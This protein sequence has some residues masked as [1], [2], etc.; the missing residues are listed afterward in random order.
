M[1]YLLDT[2][3]C[4]YAIKKK[5]ASVISRVLSSDPEEIAISTI[6]LGELEYGIN[7]SRYPDRNR[8]ALIGFLLPFAVVEFDQ[9]A[10]VHYGQIR[11]ALEARGMPIGPTDMLLGAQ[12]RAHRLILVTN[13]QGEFERIEDLEIENWVQE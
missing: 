6:T 5:S 12:A 4:V 1:K 13:N 2:N 9:R 10:A 3:T 7:K 8:F 11:A